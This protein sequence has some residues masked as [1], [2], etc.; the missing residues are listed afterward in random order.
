[1][2][3]LEKL[4][5]WTHGLGGYYSLNALENM[6]LFLISE[7]DKRKADACKFV[8]DAFDKFLEDAKSSGKIKRYQ[9]EIVDLSKGE[10]Q[11]RFGD[12]YGP[13]WEKVYS[14]SESRNNWKKEGFIFIPIFHNADNYHYLAENL[15][16]RASP[17]MF[18]VM[19]KS[20]LGVSNPSK[21]NCHTA[22]R[23][24]K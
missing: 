8:K 10:P 6:R 21:R 23:L 17:G 2:N 24:D 19:E 11:E 16:D 14:S 9:V 1:M 22:I 13:F 12:G 3:A 20:Y 7:D 18:S 4:E 15:F 5:D